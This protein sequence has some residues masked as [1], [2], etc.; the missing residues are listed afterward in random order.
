MHITMK[1]WMKIKTI[2]QKVHTPELCM[3]LSPSHWEEGGR[4]RQFDLKFPCFLLACFLFCLR[5]GSTLNW[6]QGREVAHLSIPMVLNLL[7]EAAWQNWHRR[8]LI[9]HPLLPSPLGTTTA[10]VHILSN[11]T[12]FRLDWRLLCVSGL[13][14]SV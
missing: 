12:G 8:Y 13:L 9:I 10:I 4:K 1:K 7:L 14:N 3:F 11:N 6:F 5:S 2:F